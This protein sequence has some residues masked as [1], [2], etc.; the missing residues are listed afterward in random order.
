MSRISG[1]EAILRA[2]KMAG[3]DYLVANPGSDFAPIIEAYAANDGGDDLPRPILAPHENI[4]VSMAHG[5]WLVTGR[6]LA[7][8]VH[9]NVGLANAVMAMLNAHSDD[10]PL[11]LLSGRNPLT[12]GDRPGSRRTPIQY[13]QEM[14]D[15]TALVR[16]TVKWDYELRYAENAADL[17][18]R[19]VAIAKS[20]PQGAVYLSL[21]REP[22]AE[23]VD[24]PTR[25]PQV[26]ASDPH[27]DPR[28]IDAAAAALKS[29]QNP[30]IICAR[31]DPEGQVSAQ[32]QALAEEQGIEVS[33]VFVTRNV[34]PSDHPCNIGGNVVQTLPGRDVVLVVDT[35]VAWIETKVSPDPGATV[36][37][38]GPDPLI[39]RIPVRGYRTTQAIQG[40]TAA[41]LAALRVALGDAR[42]PK[43]LSEASSKN[44]AFRDRIRQAAADGAKG[45]PSKAFV[46]QCVSDLVGKDGVIFSERGGPASTFTLSRPNQWFGNTQAGGLGWCVPAAL[47]AQL[48][49]RNRLVVAV[50][51]DG[52]YVFSNPVAS[53]Q[54]AL[55]EGLPLLIVVLNNAGYDAV[56]TSTLEVYP[57][58]A[59][60]RSNQ[61]P[62]VP[63]DG[64]PDHAAVARA[65]GCFAETVIE[66][67][68]MAAALSRAAGHIRQT[69]TPAVLNIRV[70]LD[71]GAK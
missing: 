60:A 40:D 47:G 62:L 35:P 43:R 61:M 30:L 24:M 45:P 18:A 65:M 68:D 3:I 12:E 28:A 31:G 21:P 69:R 71:D 56:R 58:G 23:E 53:L 2:L 42:N 4:T 57:K 14:F 54:V 27:P 26:P 51:G 46:A 20:A 8:A 49:D 44:A 48:A 32:L 39:A 37:H 11:F 7:A 15:Q 66:G 59:A 1:G 36:I 16:E 10:V 5:Y 67:A 50:T 64:N 52:S 22:L 6:I 34:M 25:L 13:G 33:E 9:V 19:G 70:R 63:F 29:A 38:I 41:G 55:A 17:V